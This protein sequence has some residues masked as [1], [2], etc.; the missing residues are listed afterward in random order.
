MNCQSLLSGKIRKP[1]LKRRLLKFL[2]N[3]LSVKHNELFATENVGLADHT[4]LKVA[5]I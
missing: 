5:Y 2:L 1:F 3:M 4:C